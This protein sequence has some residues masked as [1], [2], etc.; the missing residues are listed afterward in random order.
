MRRFTTDQVNNEPVSQRD[1]QIQD[2]QRVQPEFNPEG[3][4]DN[5]IQAYHDALL[6][7]FMKKATTNDSKGKG[8]DKPEEKKKEIDGYSEDLQKVKM[9]RLNMRNRKKTKHNDSSDS[10]ADEIEKNKQSRLNMRGK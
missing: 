1:A 4:S 5:Y 8:K 7:N 3:K 10:S 9:E 2:I 6:E